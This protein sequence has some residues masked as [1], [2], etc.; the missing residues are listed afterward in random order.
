LTHL[1]IKSHSVFDIDA[2]NVTMSNK[3]Q[4]IEIK[5]IIE[6]FIVSGYC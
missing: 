2:V 4:L 1:L 3:T 5:Y 6:L